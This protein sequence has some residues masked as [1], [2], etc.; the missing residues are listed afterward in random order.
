MVTDFDGND[1]FELVRLEIVGRICI[2]VNFV[3]TIHKHLTTPAF[4]GLAMASLQGSFLIASPHLG[5]GNFNRSVVLMVKHDDEGAFGFVLN[6]PTG[7]TVAEIWKLVSDVDS[8]RRD[9][10]YLGGPVQGPLM[11]VHGLAA[12]AES[13]ILEGVYLSAHKD[14]LREVVAAEDIP[15]RLFT[16]Y[17]GWG[18]GQL[19][20][21]LEAGGW[22]IAPATAGLV[23]H[24]KDDLWERVMHSVAKEILAPSLKPRHVPNDPTLN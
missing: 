20:G 11:A 3:R 14:Q 17:S 15:F 10:I 6:R 16:G 12:A 7:N 1:N 13:E 24:E 5:D 22:L 9:P 18:A 21:E 4:F 2:T 23:F 8:E 19:E